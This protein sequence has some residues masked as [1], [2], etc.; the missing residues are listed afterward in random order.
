M[1]PCF[2]LKGSLFTLS[3][4]QLQNNNLTQLSQQLSEKIK[5]APKFFQHAPVVIDLQKLTAEQPIDFNM[6]SKVLREHHLIPVGVRGTD[7]STQTL[8]QA[9]GFATMI[10]APIPEAAKEKSSKPTQAETIPASLLPER[11]GS[12]LITQPIRSGQ[13]VYA[14]GGDLVVVSSVSP[15]SELLA[16][17]NI[18]IYGTLRGRALAGINGDEKARIFCH[19][20]EAELVSIAGQYKIFEDSEAQQHKGPVQL[21]LE[22]G[23]LI[24]SSM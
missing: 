6:L 5:L 15:G 13:Q 3:I 9:A 16:D 8:A 23:Q 11:K 4:L 2:Q 19:G 17:G 24:I 12:R 21:Y 22:N 20:L 7:E 18:H 10:D 14:Q 1:E